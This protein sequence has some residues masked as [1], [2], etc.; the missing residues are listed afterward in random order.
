MTDKEG[1]KKIA[2][3]LKEE[4]NESETEGVKITASLGISTYPED[5]TN[6]FELLE[7][8]DKYAY[9]SKSLG[10]DRVY[11]WFKMFKTSL[12]LFSQ[13]SII[14]SKI[15]LHSLFVSFIKISSLIDFKF[16]FTFK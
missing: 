16:I 1:A 11:Y 4:I 5:A 2:E 13:N 8:A 10:G 14:S 12:K 9:L 3:R 15:F 6:S 7:K